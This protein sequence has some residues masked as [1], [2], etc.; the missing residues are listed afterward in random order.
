MIRLEMIPASDIRTGDTLLDS[1]CFAIGVVQRVDT[2]QRFVGGYNGGQKT[3]YRYTV[4]VELYEDEF[5]S[6]L[7]PNPATGD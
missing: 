1:E 2:N 6:V 3:V 5:G 4:V 7:R